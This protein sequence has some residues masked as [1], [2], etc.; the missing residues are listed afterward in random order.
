MA[1]SAG[2]R[3]SPAATSQAFRVEP[4]AEPGDE[5]RPHQRAQVGVPAHQR[6]LTYHRLDPA[7]DRGSPSLAPKQRLSNTSAAYAS[8]IRP[9]ARRG[10]G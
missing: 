5:V 1:S 2:T 10:P 9:G 4:L 7:V 3:W 6:H 8:A